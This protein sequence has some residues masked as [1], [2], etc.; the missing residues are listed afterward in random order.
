MVCLKAGD[1][2]AGCQNSSEEAPAADLVQQ[3]TDPLETADTPNSS[4]EVTP[5]LTVE[6]HVDAEIAPSPPRT[7]PPMW[8]PLQS[9]SVSE[10]KMD[11]LQSPAAMQIDIVSTYIGCSVAA[12]KI[13]R[14]WRRYRGL[15]LLAGMRSVLHEAIRR[16]KVCRK[17]LVDATNGLKDVQERVQKAVHMLEEE[18][19]LASAEAA[20]SLVEV[21][22]AERSHASVLEADPNPNPKPNPNPNPDLDPQL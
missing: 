6:T 7:W 21:Q 5:P 9:L 18:Y 22:E 19:A 11:G 2:E 4:A 3:Q 15:K 13:Q 12:C 1:E 17:E 8:I 10:E 16:M 20:P 14:A